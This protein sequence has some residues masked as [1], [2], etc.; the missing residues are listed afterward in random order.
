MGPHGSRA[1]VMAKDNQGSSSGWWQLLQGLFNAEIYKRSQGRLVRQFTC[2]AIWVAFALSAWRSYPTLT[3]DWHVSSVAAYAISGAILV[4][5][6]W[7]GFRIVN[8]PTFAD[9][10]I[11]VEAEMNKVSWPSRTELIRASMVVIIL[12]FGLATV[13]YGYDVI[14]NVLLKAIGV[15]T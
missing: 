5:G 9:F 15:I 8:L 2:L 12:M 13:L 4:V 3:I 14:L 6:L 10:L 1:G 7:L 11:A